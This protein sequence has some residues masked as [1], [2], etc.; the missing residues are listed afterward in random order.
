LRAERFKDAAVERLLRL[1]GVEIELDGA[2][3]VS[4]SIS[5]EACGYGG[6]EVWGVGET[7]AA[8]DADYGDERCA[9]RGIERLV[10]W[11][12]GDVV[13]EDVGFGQVRDADVGR[14]GVE[15]FRFFPGPEDAGWDAIDE[16]CRE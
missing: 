5:G 3:V 1:G 4:D 14:E 8:F 11:Q 6:A 12:Y 2:Y 13:G 7:G 16:G 9:G 15:V 10:A